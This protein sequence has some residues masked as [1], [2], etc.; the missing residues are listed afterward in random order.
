MTSAFYSNK[1]QPHRNVCTYKYRPVR[2]VQ[3][4]LYAARI[5]TTVRKDQPLNNFQ[6]FPAGRTGIV[7]H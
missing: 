2:M 1:L 7:E 4:L 3:H 5:I 6:P